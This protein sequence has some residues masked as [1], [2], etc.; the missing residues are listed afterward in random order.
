MEQTLLLNA[1]FEPITVVPWQ[2]AM[3]LWAKGLVEVVEEHDREVRAVSFSFR[4]PS[5]VR[6]LKY[7]R[8]RSR[9]SSLPFTRANVYA[10]DN[11][12]CQYCGSHGRGVELTF[13]HV[14][15]ESAGG[16]KSWDNIVTAC[17]PCNKRKGARTPDEAGMKLRR[18]PVRPSAAV[19]VVV[20]V[21][22]VPKNWLDFLYWNV[23]LDED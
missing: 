16:G 20:G 18:K 4:L 2:R 8:I 12:S 14:V 21:R 3:T 13:D 11:H 19:R 7:V 6:L 9:S 10:R 5:I 17:L 15:P 1:T 23:E 22:Q